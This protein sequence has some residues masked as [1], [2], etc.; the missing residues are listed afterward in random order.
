MKLGLKSF[1]KIGGWLCQRIANLP[2]AGNWRWWFIRYSG[3]K[4][5]IPEGGGRH[6]VYIGNDVTWDSAYPEEI[7]IGNN[8]H[9]TTGCVLLTHYMTINEKGWIEWHRGHIKIADDVFIGA[10]TVIT[11]PVTIGKGAVIGAGSVVTKDIPPHEIWAGVPAK[12]IKKI[13]IENE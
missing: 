6:F 12:F 9:I 3:V 13:N 11:K 8:V 1:K 10:K 4:F 5:H 7:E 2:M